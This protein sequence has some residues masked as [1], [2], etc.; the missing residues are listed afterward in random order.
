MVLPAVVDG[1]NEQEK[2]LVGEEQ[3]EEG[4]NGAGDLVL[5][6]IHRVSKG[7]PS[8]QRPHLDW[9]LETLPQC[10]LRQSCSL[11]GRHSH[12]ISTEL[13]TYFGCQMSVIL[14]HSKLFT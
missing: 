10:S 9:P 6:A 7:V 4:G 8:S 5:V 14:T 13:Q 12:S 11:S 1:N 2:G 3:Q